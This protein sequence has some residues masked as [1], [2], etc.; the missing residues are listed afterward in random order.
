MDHDARHLIELKDSPPPRGSGLFAK[1]LIPR[2]TRIIAEPALL[3]VSDSAN[4]H[5][6]AILH[7]Y[8]QLPPQKQEQYLSLHAHASNTHKKH[9]ER[10]LQ[11]EFSQ[12]PALHRMVLSIY[13]A[14]A[15]TGVFLLTSRINHSCLPNCSA[16][17]NRSLEE[18]TVHAVRD[19]RAGEELTVRYVETSRARAQRQSELA[20]WGFRCGCEVCEDTLEG[21]MRE[22]KRMQLFQLDQSLAWDTRAGGN[23]EAWR[24]ALHTARKT[25]ALQKAEGLVGRELGNSWVLTLRLI[26]SG[27]AFGLRFW[28][29]LGTMSLLGCA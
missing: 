7:A 19:I 10:E 21:R 20:K 26:G 5:A 16:A 22:E 14:N 18:E 24:R 23:E 25:A 13:A 1:A 12:L 8:E 27:N 4:V 28:C 11:Q 6:T 9:F 29:P 3:R 17:Y 15:F 2:G